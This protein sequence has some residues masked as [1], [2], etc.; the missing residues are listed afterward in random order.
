MDNKPL[1]LTIKGMM[2]AIAWAAV[3]FWACS[4]PLTGSGADTAIPIAGL[5]TMSFFTAL[6]APFERAIYGMILG[7]VIAVVWIALALLMAVR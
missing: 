6:A 3:F 5:R 1:R 4:I 7:L 2:L